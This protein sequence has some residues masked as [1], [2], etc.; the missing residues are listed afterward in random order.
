M[1]DQDVNPFGDPKDVNPFADP[2]IKSATADT[3][4]GLDDYNP[5]A[6][7]ATRGTTAP[8][9]NVNPPPVYTQPATIEPT[10]AEVPPEYTSYTPNQVTERDE[11]IKRQEE[12]ERKAD[13]LARKENELR[14]LQQRGS[15]ENNFPPLPAKFCCKPCFYHDISVDIPVEYQRLCRMMYYLWQFYSLALLFNMISSL[16]LLCVGGENGAQTFGVSLLYLFLFVPCSFLFW[17]RPVYQALKNDSSFN[18]MLY[19]FVFFFQIIFAIVYAVGIPGF[20]TSGWINGAKTL[21]KH[22]KVVAVMMFVSG[23]LFTVISLLSI[24]LLRKVHYIYRTTGASLEKAQGEFARGVVTNKNVQNA[25]AEAVKGS[26][27]AQ[28]R[29]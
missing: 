22:S 11:V 19:F 1:A 16:A 21:D 26:M 9:H 14:A 25:A 8:A 17:Y 13:E 28:T 20:G 27:Q 29:Y 23:A 2:D 18:F 12:L 24:F 7:H 5:F 10:R 15:P 3:Q 6:E 4:K